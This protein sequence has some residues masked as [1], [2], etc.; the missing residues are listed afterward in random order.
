M[1]I[2]I[3]ENKGINLAT[4]S[5]KTQF[6]ALLLKISLRKHASIAIN[7]FVSQSCFNVSFKIRYQG[8]LQP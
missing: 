3:F 7:D 6:E 5:R 4:D 8:Q 2:R 1:G